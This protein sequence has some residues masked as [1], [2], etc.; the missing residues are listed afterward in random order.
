MKGNIR[1]WMHYLE[2]RTSEDTQKEHREIANSIDE[3][4]KINFP[5]ISEALQKKKDG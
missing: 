3:I 1:S 4:F 5:N 2:L